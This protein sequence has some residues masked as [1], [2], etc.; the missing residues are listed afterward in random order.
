MGPEIGQIEGRLL[1]KDTGQFLVAVSSV[2]MLR[3][4]EQIRRHLSR[5]PGLETVSQADTKSHVF[6]LYRRVQ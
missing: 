2:R 1:E 3:G 5:N 4:G 6:A